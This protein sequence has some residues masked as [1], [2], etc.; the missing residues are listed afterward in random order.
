MGLTE[1]PAKKRTNVRFI[2]FLATLTVI[3][4]PPLSAGAPGEQPDFS[5][6]HAARIAATAALGEGAALVAQGRWEDARRAFE[7][8]VSW[9]PDLAA[10]HFNL[11]VTLGVL[12]RS[13]EALGAYRRAIRLAP[14]MVEAMVNLGVELFKRGQ[15]TEAL[16]SLERA[17]RVAPRSAASHRLGRSA[18]GD[19]GTGTRTASPLQGTGR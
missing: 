19:S 3:A 14:M 13:D 17:V 11:G 4:Q 15:T 12:G 7:R 9:N 8:A 18:G 5:L 16:A 2:I 10:A 1:H 6:Q